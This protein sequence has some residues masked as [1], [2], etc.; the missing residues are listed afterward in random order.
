MVLNT[1]GRP[2][3]DS[4]MIPFCK[5]Q[6]HDGVNTSALSFVLPALAA[7]DFAILGL[8]MSAFSPVTC[9][10]LIS[11]EKPNPDPWLFS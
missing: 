4:S 11:S 2:N 7:A 5:L 1:D 9:S 10:S 8:T 6:T 3:H